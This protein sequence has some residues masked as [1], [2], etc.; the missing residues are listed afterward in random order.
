ME[1]CMPLQSVKAVLVYVLCLMGTDILVTPLLLWLCLPARLRV[2]QQCWL[3]RITVTNT[4]AS[5]KCIS[6]PWGNSQFFGQRVLPWEWDEWP[7]GPQ[8]HQLYHSS[9]WSCRDTA[10]QYPS[11]PT[12]RSVQFPSAWLCPL[13]FLMSAGESANFLFLDIYFWRHF[14]N[15]YT[16]K[17]RLANCC[18]QMC[19]QSHIQFLRL[20]W[21]SWWKVM[22]N[23]LA[24][25]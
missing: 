18:F 10:W 6:R 20:L 17:W 14:M 7:G 25:S 8:Q 22:Q 19:R 24:P 12:H 15:K 4:S 13:V 9:T 21:H 23:T 16:L 2:F 3:L 11:Q 1:W 5:P